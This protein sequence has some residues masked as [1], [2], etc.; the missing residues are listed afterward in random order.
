[1]DKKILDDIFNE[2]I[3]KPT[4][5]EMHHVLISDFINHFTTF[6]FMLL[7]RHIVDAEK[8]DEDAK[9]AAIGHL[10]DSVANVWEEK[11][12]NEV[13]VNTQMYADMFAKNEKSSFLTQEEINEIAKKFADNETKNVLEVSKTFK[14]IFNVLKERI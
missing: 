2:T 8:V 9:K 5:N 13:C 7:A 10:L 4:L 3:N 6:T 11:M 1:M 12:L 14:D